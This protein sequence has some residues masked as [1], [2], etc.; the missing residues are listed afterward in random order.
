[1]M[2]PS[3]CK[4][5][6]TGMYTSIQDEGR[7]GWRHQGVPVSGPMDRESF[8][9]ANTLLG[10]MPNAACLEI[11]QLGP[12]LLFNDPTWVGVSG[13]PLLIH[14]NG[15]E[16]AMGVPIFCA[17][18]DV[19]RLGPMQKG[20]RSYL[21]F[22]GG[23]QTDRFLGSRSQFYPISPKA[24]LEKGIKLYFNA[25]TTQPPEAKKVT[26]DTASLAE[27]NSLMVHKGLDWDACPKAIRRALFSKTLCIGSNNRMGYRIQADLP[28]T[29]L[30]PL[31]GIVLP[32][33]VQLTPGGNL[34]IAMQDGQVTGGYL[35]ILQLD[36]A[37]INYLAQQTTGKTLQL[38]WT[39]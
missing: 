8:T 20:V 2:K 35:R 12:T 31:S 26:Y 23:L 39:A 19:L 33:T 4:V 28:T 3:F 13:A 1:M 25:L 16:Q 22:Q 24:T 10:N 18:G 7:L 38:Q 5:I 29:D 17:L 14:K 21:A 30:Q 37:A 27:K 32:G 11:T 9:R 34:L 6:E 15:E 36:Q